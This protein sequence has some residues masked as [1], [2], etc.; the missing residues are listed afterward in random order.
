MTGSQALSV[1]RFPTAHVGLALALS[2]GAASLVAPSGGGTRRSLMEGQ[3]LVLQTFG[4]RNPTCMEWSDSCSI[5][6]R[7]DDG[8]AKCS[9]VGI[10]CVSGEL[11]CKLEKAK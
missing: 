3:E 9:T 2:L 4:D 1:P 8:K 6:Q 11:V 10:A 7:G 5:C